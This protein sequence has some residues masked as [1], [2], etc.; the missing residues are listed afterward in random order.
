MTKTLQITLLGLTLCIG[1][2]AQEPSSALNNAV[3]QNIQSIES[4]DPKASNFDD[5]AFLSDELNGV[6]IV[7]LGEQSHGDGSTFLAKTRLIK[8]L[9]E[10]QGYDVLVF[11]SGLIDV[12]RTWKKIQEGADSLSVFNYGIFPI[13]ARSQQVEE[14]FTYILEQADSENPLTIAGFDIQPTGTLMKPEDR[15]SEITSYLKKTLNFQEEDYPFFM[16]SFSNLRNVMQNPLTS[17]EYQA[18]KKEY[19]ILQKQILEVDDSREGMIFSRYIDNYFKTITLY[20]KADLRKPPNTPHVFNIRD[21]EMARNF[22]LIINDLYPGNKFI[23]WG[24][25][26]HLG[27]G[28]GL[29]EDFQD[30]KPSAPAMIPFGQYLKIDYQSSLYTIS[31]TSYEGK[32][33]L[34]NG[35]ERELPSGHEESL[36]N[37]LATKENPYLFL[38]LK[39]NDFRTLSFPARIY[40]H[41]EMNGTWANMTDGIFFIRTMEPNKL[42]E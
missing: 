41:A 29:L 40:G 27:Y 9:H 33:G 25:N 14:L 24:A 36:E 17:E 12:Y 5:L 1:S 22:E 21:R 42:I 15:V 39:D 32:I 13:W 23:V 7:M 26:S 30:R 10:E 31:F 34:F 2:I 3:N 38:S 18:M 16:K 6:D 8:Y 28:R 35:T 37:L 19:S 4:I 11:E 20:S